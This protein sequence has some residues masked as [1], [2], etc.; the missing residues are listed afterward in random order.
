M[1]RIDIAQIIES[2]L[3]AQ[4]RQQNAIGFHAQARLEQLLRGHARQPLIVF[5][6]EQTHMIGMPVEHQL[7]GV[8]DSDQALI[9][10]YL[11]DQRFG[12]S[13]F[14]RAGRTGHQDVLARNDRQPHERLIFPGGQKLEQFWFSLVT[15]LAGASGLTK[16]A[17][18]GQLFDRPLL[19][20]GPA[21]R[22]G[23]RPGGRRRRQYDLY[24]LAA[25]QRGREQWRGGVDA[26]ASEVG[27]QLGKSYTPVE[28]DLR[29][30]LAPPACRR[31][32]QAPHSVKPLSNGDWPRDPKT[33]P[34]LYRNLRRFSGG[35]H[36]TRDTSRGSSS[37]ADGRA[38]AASRDRSD[39]GTKHRA[40]TDFR[41]VIS[42]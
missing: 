27:H 26:L 24:S 3:G 12:P 19:A 18:A 21:N 16:N 15:I 13:G 11:A 33:D 2:L 7:L 5:R 20:G 40:H 10:R 32:H 22:D 14:A 31:F 36:D 4:F 6:I 29:D 25:G 9:A 8:L 1:S 39:R 28:A 17:G 41:C 37:N 35:E 34:R 30:D 38:L 23:H 42:G